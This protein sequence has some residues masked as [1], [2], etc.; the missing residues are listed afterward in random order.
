MPVVGLL[1][2]ALLVVGGAHHHADG[3]NHV[4]AVCS[5]GHSPAV[6]PQVTA[7]A[8]VPTELSRRVI[9][10]SPVAPPLAPHRDRFQPRS[11]PGLTFP[12]PPRALRA[13]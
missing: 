13:T 2:L 11:S 5:V 6:G 9:A 4:C 10:A 8:A 7:P 1:F 12:R 3:G